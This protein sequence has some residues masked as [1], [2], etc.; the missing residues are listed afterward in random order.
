[1]IIFLTGHSAREIKLEEIKKEFN[2]INIYDSNIKSE[3]FDFF[4]N[5]SNQSIFSTNELRILKR[6][7]KIKDFK[8]LINQLK[9]Y[10]NDNQTIVI[11]YEIE[12]KTKNPYIKDFEQINAQIINIDNYENI[13]VEYIVNSLGV[14]KA[15]AKKIIDIVGDD[16]NH[17]KN[18]LYKI[19]SLDI[20]KDYEDILMP[21]MDKKIYE[22]VENIINNKI[23]F[24]EIPK[25][26]YMAI[27]YSLYKEFEIYHKLSLLDLPYDHDNFKKE[28]T[29]IQPIFNANYYS[30]FLKMKK[31]YPKKKALN[32][33]MKLNEYESKIKNGRL[34]DKTA[35]WLIMQEI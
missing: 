28:Y 31:K 32:I 23:E 20:K 16:F 22:Y 3:Y 21:N 13:L 19:K 33:L 5:I 1:M 30:I 2:N 14:K 25:E 24:D 4:E 27:I 26:L 6:S 18:E 8:S 12:P 11:D 17:I 9:I 7:E 29:N 15:D 35:I 10:D 34:D